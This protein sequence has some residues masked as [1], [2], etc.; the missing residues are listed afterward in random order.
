MNMISRTKNTINFFIFYLL[1]QF[2]LDKSIVYSWVNQRLDR[3]AK[4]VFLN[5]I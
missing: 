2:I 1:T 3:R 4:N 5:V